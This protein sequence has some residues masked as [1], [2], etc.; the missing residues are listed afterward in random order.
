MRSVHAVVARDSFQYEGD[1]ADQEC[2]EHE[3]PNSLHEDF[4]VNNDATMVD[5]LVILHI[6]MMSQLYY[7]SLGGWDHA[8]LLRF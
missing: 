4:V 7:I 6:T 1:K 8:A 5:E 2:K 3:R